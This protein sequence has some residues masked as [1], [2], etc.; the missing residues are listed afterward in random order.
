M[1]GNAECI[2]VR[3][4]DGSGPEVVVL[5]GGPAAPGSAAPL[6]E[7]LAGRFRVYEPTQRGS[8]PEPL[9]V[10]RH[11][12]DLRQVIEEHC[13]SPRPALVGWSWGAMLALACA[14]EYPDE[15]GP[16]A[17]VGCGTFDLEARAEMR[18]L[19]RQRTT[20]EMQAEADHIQAT[21]TDPARRMART[22]AIMSSLYNYDSLDSPAE[23]E[24][25][26]GV[27][28]QAHS[29]TWEDMLRCQADGVYPQAFAAIRSP[30]LMLHGEYDPHP[31]PSTRGTLKA[32]IPQIE[33]VELERCGHS[34]WVERHAR[35]AFFAA[36]VDWLASVTD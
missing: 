12:A 21:E 14:A 32:F 20:P 24:P 9:T 28:A 3:S 10:A 18:R 16:I 23:V 25:L 19:L 26:N 5:H 4:Y 13:A 1:G 29:E 27:D 15:A 2:E 11:V 35:E 8:E 17:L 7:G 34:P 33:Y 30:V 22:F 6:A 31:G 36:L